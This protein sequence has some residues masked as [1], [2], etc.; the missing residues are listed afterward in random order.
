[1]SQTI[2]Q[3][4]ISR[5][6]LERIYKGTLTLHLWRALHN[7]SSRTTNPLYP[8]FETRVIQHVRFRLPDVEVMTHRGV[9]YVIARLGRGTSLFDKPGAIGSSQWFYFEIPQGTEIP[10]GIITTKDEYN[11]KYQATH[12]STLPNHTMPKPVF[13]KILDDLARNAIARKKKSSHG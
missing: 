4:L 3:L 11:E 10:N 8:D 12:Y 7:K 2:E 13:C 6:E 5:N 1:M 9:E